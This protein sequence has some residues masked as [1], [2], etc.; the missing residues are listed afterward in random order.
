MMDAKRVCISCKKRLVSLGQAT[1]DN[2][3]CIGMHEPVIQAPDLPW[4]PHNNMERVG[5]EA[6][7]NGQLSLGLADGAQ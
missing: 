7:M 3:G 4:L 2:K 5:T 6:N 1:I